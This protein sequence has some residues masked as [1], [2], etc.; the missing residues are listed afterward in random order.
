MVI[1]SNS[2]YNGPTTVSDG[3]L[4]VQGTLRSTSGMTVGQGATLELGATNMFTSGHGSAVAASRVLTADGGTL[5]MN[6][7]MDSRI[8][9]VTLANGGTWTSNRAVSGYDV[10]LA[11]TSTGAAIVTVSGTGAARMNGSGGIHL[12]GIQ[13]FAV[14][15]TTG[16]ANPDL[17]VS[18]ILAG[19][20]S[21]GGSAGGILKTGAGTMLL[22][23]SNTF[24]GGV[25]IAAGKV[26]AAHPSALGTGTVVIDG[27]TANLAWNA[28]TALTRPLTFTRATLSGTG[29][30]GVGVTVGSDRTI[31]PGN[32]VG[33]Q[34]Y[35]AGLKLGAGGS[36]A[37]EIT[38][39]TGTKG[40]GW[41]LATVSGGSLD[42]S[43]LSAAGRFGLELSPLSALGTPGSLSN[44]TA[45]SPYLWRLFATTSLV[46]PGTFG[47]FLTG[48]GTY[49]PGSDVTSLFSL[50][51]TGWLDTLPAH[52]LFSMRVGSDGRGLDLVL[53]GGPA[54]GVPEIDPGSASSV[55]G[56]VLA[57]LACAER[58]RRRG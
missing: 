49:A 27:T 54:G 10:L 8:G 33:T 42:L 7:S 38:D 58:R 20:G 32:S 16:D 34:A 9:S 12:Q 3:T 13:E 11:N 17:T 56:L 47:G 25:T 22:S 43:A 55:V 41:D 37:W 1:S 36:Y 21:A 29:V 6:A 26:V 30:I 39:A 18:M 53:A 31:A 35:A 4:R 57:A 51:T 2:S 23:G 5:L 48:A 14:A 19:P 45:G 28:S 52:N 46:L 50:V 44:Y 15:N 24:T 40:I